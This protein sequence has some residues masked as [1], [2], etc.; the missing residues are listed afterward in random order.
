MKAKQ[1]RASVIWVILL[2]LVLIINPA[3]ASSSFTSPHRESYRDALAYPPDPGLN[4]SWSGGVDGVADI[5]SAFNNARTQENNQLGT[6]IP[7]MILPSQ[8]VWDSMTDSEKAL[9]LINQER[10]AR[11]IMPLDD[12]EDNVNGVAQYYADYLF[13]NDA[14]GHNEDGNSPWE[15]LDN[16]PNIVTCHDFLSVSENIA[17]FVTSGNSIALPIERSVFMWLYD[18]AGSSWGHRHAIL[19]YPYNDNS[20]QVGQEGFLGIGRANGGPYQG[21]FSSS[22]HFAELIVMNVFD[23]CSIWV[24]PPPKVIS[25]IRANASPTNAPSVD[26]IVTFSGAVTGVDTSDF[27]LTTM[28]VNGASISSSVGSGDRYT[29]SVA[30]GS[31]N[32]TIRLDVLDDDSI[33]DGSSSPLGGAGTGNGDYRSGQV[34]DIATF[35]D[36]PTTHWAY[37]FIETLFVNSVTG[38]CGGGNYC[39]DS[40]VTRAQMAVFLLKGKYGSSYSPPVAGGR[41]GDVPTTYWA[42]SWIEQLATEGI[43]GGCGN[44]NYCPDAAVTRDQMAVFLLK[45]NYGSSYSPPAAVGVFGDVPTSYWS[46][47]WIEQLVA[48]SITAGCSSGNYCPDNSVTRAQM[49]VFLVKTFN[50]SP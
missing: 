28:G 4:I 24:S 44:G 49:A 22:W 16:N 40:F 3:Q 7:A 41:F 34:Y 26:F 29:I 33:I 13:D 43:T 42:A 19:W 9:W 10:V 1:K 12:I 17:V 36:V 8:T 5:Q 48:E 30:T 11:S 35:L 25:I 15:R 14:W 20:G 18:D 23:P 50:L 47:N 2:V 27:T 39:P 21:P 6:F 32:G 31:G 46:A 38:G 37:S 45:A